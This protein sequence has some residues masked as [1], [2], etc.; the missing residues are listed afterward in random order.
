VP[1]SLTAAGGFE[2][3]SAPPL[4]LFDYADAVL[5]LWDTFSIR[6]GG[7]WT[8]VTKIG[9]VTSPGPQSVEY[10]F[11][12]ATDSS[13]ALAIWQPFALQI[14]VGSM[15][16]REVIRLYRDL[17]RAVTGAPPG[18]LALYPHQQ[19]YWGADTNLYRSGV[20]ALKTDGT[21]EATQLKLTHALA[22]ANST[23]SSNAAQQ[24]NALL[25][26]LRTKGI[27]AP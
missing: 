21:I 13:T 20:G 2:L 24:L 15:P 10:I 7:N 26:Y 6:L 23:D 16:E 12:I 17:R 18:T 3:N 1:Q 22:I 14:P 19:F 11:T 5:P 9:K 4:P 27:L 8:L 25:A